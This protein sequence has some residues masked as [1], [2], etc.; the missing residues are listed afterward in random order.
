MPHPTDR[1]RLSLCLIPFLVAV[2]TLWLACW[3]YDKMPTWATAPLV[4][5][6]GLI[7]V[8]SILFG[9]GLVS[10]RYEDN[11]PRHSGY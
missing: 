3:L 11:S 7:I 8:G 6:A 5:T 4:I 1:P 2:I 10:M 9:G